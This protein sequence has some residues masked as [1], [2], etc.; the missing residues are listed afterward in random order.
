MRA[1]LTGMLALPCGAAAAEVPRTEARAT[2]VP[3]LPYA[4]TQAP[5]G[6][7]FDHASCA[8]I[9]HPPSLSARP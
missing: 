2:G 8:S 3:A 1:A 6:F 5:R 7:Q 4:L 9:E